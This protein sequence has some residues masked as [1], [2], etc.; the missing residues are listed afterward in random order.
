MSAVL[1]PL[2]TRSARLVPV[3]RKVA[4]LLKAGRLSQSIA[5]FSRSCIHMHINRL[6]RSRARE[7]ELVIYDALQRLY[8]SMLARQTRGSRTGAAEPKAATQR[9]SGEGN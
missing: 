2:E 8:E 1:K 3:A 9:A 5:E 7:F 6:L 4:E